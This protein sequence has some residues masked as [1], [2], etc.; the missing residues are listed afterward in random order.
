MHESPREGEIEYTLQADRWGNRNRKIRWEKDGGREY[1]RETTR[2][3]LY[4]G[5][6]LET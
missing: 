6:T 3:G 1:L 2:I 5:D 4:L